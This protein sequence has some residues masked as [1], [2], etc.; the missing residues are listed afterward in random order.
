MLRSLLL[1]FLL[2]AV[3]ACGGED[4][5][6]DFGDGSPSDSGIRRDTG[7]ADLGF[8]L[9]AA[10][11]DSGV[12]FDAGFDDAGQPVDVGFPPDSGT[13]ADSGQPVDVGFPPDSGTPTDSG[14]PTDSGTPNDSG[15]PTDVGFPDSGTVADLSDDFAGNN[16]NGAWSVFHPE[17][18]NVAVSGG[19]LR[20]SVIQHA[21][22]FQ[23][24]EG[25]LI[26]KNVTGDFKLTSAVQARRTT[27]SNLA[28]DRYVHL[29]GLMARDGNSASE[30]YVFIV[31]GYDEN[32]LSVETKTTVNGNSTFVGP[33]WPSG[34]AELRLCRV[35]NTFV[36]YKRAI[37]A[38]SWTE[39]AR[40]DRPD[41]PA[42]LQVGP[43]AY[44][45]ATGM[46][47]APDLTV[48]FDAAVF[49]PVSGLADCA[50]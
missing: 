9:D 49:A 12:P 30:N 37:G 35:G 46:P 14:P 47:G 26:Y 16:L 15:A 1:L 18:L 4:E 34:D 10:P 41:L 48:N 45:F 23:N 5:V 22:W 33:S 43:N 40:W 27:N 32:D 7:T 38:G 42:T 24:D 19:S 13:P 36:V 21:L 50:N 25:T 29:G 39:A 2:T 3:V 8:D 31:V 17:L 11:S 6:E 44:A 28:A 20:M